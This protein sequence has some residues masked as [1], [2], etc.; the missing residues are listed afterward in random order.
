MTMDN[1]YDYVVYDC[2]CLYDLFL[3]N[4]LDMG[5]SKKELKVMVEE[6]KDKKDL[7]KLVHR[8]I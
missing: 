4:V 1:L 8:F 2:Y 5:I 6:C 7:R 3:E